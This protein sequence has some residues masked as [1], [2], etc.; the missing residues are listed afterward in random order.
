M[1]VGG[2]LIGGRRGASLRRISRSG[3][4][5]CLLDTAA[6]TRDGQGRDDAFVDR[7]S[8]PWLLLSWQEAA[9]ARPS[10]HRRRQRPRQRPRQRSRRRHRNRPATHG[11]LISPNWIRASA[12][13]IRTRSRTI[14]SR[15]G[16]RSSTSFRRRSRP[17]RLT[18]PSSGSRVSSACSTPTPGSA[19]RFTPMTRCSI[20]SLTGGSSSGRE[21]RRS[22]VPASCR[23]AATRSMRSR[24][25]CGRSCRRT[26]R[27]ASSMAWVPRCRRSSSFMAS[28]SSTILQSPASSS[29]DPTDRGRPST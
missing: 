13:C 28:A 24:Q 29:S 22:S 17:R 27:A 4:R 21:M 19:G 14:P 26:T 11:R 3:D 25:P 9:R 1:T 10:N 12:R 8:R 15:S 2:G 5:S 6:G 23:S 7:S 18:R 20:G 16:W